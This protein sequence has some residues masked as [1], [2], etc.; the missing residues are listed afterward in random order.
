MVMYELGVV[1]ALQELAPDILKSA[2]RIYGASSGAAVAALMLCECDIG[3]DDA[4]PFVLCLKRPSG[5]FGAFS[6]VLDEWLIPR[7]FA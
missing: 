4:R 3:K 2:C 5:N 6:V 1:A 7:I